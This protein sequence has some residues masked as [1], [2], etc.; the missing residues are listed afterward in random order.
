[1]INIFTLRKP[2]M[3]ILVVVMLT[4][5]IQGI[6]YGQDRGKIYW[7]EDGKIRRA[8]LNGTAVEDVV[9]KQ[10]YIVD[11]TLDL[12]NHKIYWLNWETNDDHEIDETK[13]IRCANLDGTNIE[14]VITGQE[15]NCIALDPQTNKLYWGSRGFKGIQRANLDGSNIEDI[16]NEPVGLAMNIELDLNVGKMYW[17]D[18]LLQEIGRANLDGTNI[19]NIDVGLETILGLALDVR[20]RLVYWS[21]SGRGIIYR[22]S[23]NGHNVEDLITGLQKPIDIALDL[24]SQKIYWL[25]DS[26]V[27]NSKIQRANLDGSNVKDIITSLNSVSAIALDIEG[28]YDVSPDTKMLTTIWAKMKAQ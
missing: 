20:N 26:M 8:N 24:R 5:A 15:I 19:E 1:M 9:K 7:S 13:S 16:L 6:S 27:M 11:I 18:L 12:H 4:S 28:I 23:F 14:T 3:L 2:F 22:A 10:E 21:N 25:S 17:T